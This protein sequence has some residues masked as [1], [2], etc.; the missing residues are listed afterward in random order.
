MKNYL[1]SLI[2]LLF[3]IEQTEAQIITKTPSWIVPITFTN[4]AVNKNLVKDGY[5]YLM[6]DEQYNT[7]KGEGY[8]H[9]ALSAITEEALV[10]VSQFEFKF[11]PSIKREYFIKL[12]FIE[13]E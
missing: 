12:L 13:T 2:A 10:N 9:Y 3:I 7:V 11:D 5:Y 1:L 8:F 4:T 6:I